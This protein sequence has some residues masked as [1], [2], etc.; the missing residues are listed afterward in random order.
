MLGSYR[1]GT[2]C[3]TGLIGGGLP[4]DVILELRPDWWEEAQS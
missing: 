2:G 1:A 4:E 3:L